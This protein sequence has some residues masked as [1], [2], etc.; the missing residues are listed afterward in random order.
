MAKYDAVILAQRVSTPRPLLEF[1]EA[2][3][4]QIPQLV[5]RPV[6]VPLF[7]PVAFGTVAFGRYHRV[8][9]QFPNGGYDFIGVIGFIRQQALRSNAL[10]QRQRLGAVGKQYPR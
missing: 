3:S 2:V 6:I 7:P 4:H 1:Q 8:H 9:S 10:N 5:Q